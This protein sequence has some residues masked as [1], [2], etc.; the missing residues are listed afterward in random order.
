[1]KTANL[2]IAMNYYCYISGFPDLKAGE[3]QRVPAMHQLRVELKNVLTAADYELLRLLYAKWDNANF[4]RLLNDKNAP[5]DPGGELDAADW[6]ELF[7]LLDEQEDVRDRRLLPYLKTFYDAQ[8][9]ENFGFDGLLAEDYLAGLYYEHAMHCANRFVSRWFEFSLNVNNFLT[10]VSCRRHGFER[11]RFIIGSN[12]VAT[13]LRKSNARD[14]GLTG[15]FEQLAALQTISETEDL[16]LREQQLAALKWEWL[17]EHS[18]FSYFG[19]ERILSLVL[20]CEIINRL[21]EMNRERGTA[22][23]R[24]VLDELRGSVAFEA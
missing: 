11:G 23:F 21:N 8:K 12:D 5:L 14:F 7:N 19:I 13:E 6:Q 1:M 20:K 24:Q 18:F 3:R 10:A 4:L 15:M 9:D 16:L 2:S 17:D 22:V